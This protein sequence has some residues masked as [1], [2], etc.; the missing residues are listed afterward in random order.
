MVLMRVACTQ[1]EN[2]ITSSKIKRINTSSMTA[3]SLS[4]YFSLTRNDPLSWPANGPLNAICMCIDGDTVDMDTIPVPPESGALPVSSELNV[5]VSKALSL[6]I[7][8]KI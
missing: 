7:V 5:S 4:A 3:R 6:Q 1:Y 2:K 8:I